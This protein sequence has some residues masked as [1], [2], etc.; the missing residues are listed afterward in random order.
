MQF[1]NTVLI[2]LLASVASATTINNFVQTVT[3]VTSFVPADASINSDNDLVY[4]TVIDGTNTIV[5]TAPNGWL[6]TSIEGGHVVTTTAPSNIAVESFTHTTT[7]PETQ[8]VSNGVYY[9]TSSYDDKGLL[10]TA[11]IKQDPRI[12][13]T[14]TT[15]DNDGKPH[16]YYISESTSGSSTQYVTLSG[17]VTG[18][19]A[20]TPTTDSSLASYTTGSS[21]TT[22]SSTST[23]LSSTNGAILN[24][25]KA[26]SLAGLVMGA[27]VF[28]M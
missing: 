21:S 26:G 12:K 27:A 10:V 5:S 1:S 11:Y 24:R 7:Y 18:L 20:S 16:T 2:S 17:D 23:N 28:F 22:T 19:T 3:G 14:S 13:Y 8:V 25:Q 15:Y 6:T 9:T 4:S